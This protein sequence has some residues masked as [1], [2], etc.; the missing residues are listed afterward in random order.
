MFSA[1]GREINSIP[2]RRPPV[3]G[4]ALGYDILPFQGIP[5]KLRIRLSRKYGAKH[6]P[7]L[8]SAFLRVISGISM[9]RLTPHRRKVFERSFKDLTANIVLLCFPQPLGLVHVESF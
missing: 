4:V 2:R 7:T 6:V 3:V 5:A 9:S 8:G 1:K